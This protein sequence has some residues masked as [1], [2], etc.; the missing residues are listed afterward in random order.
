MG[1]WERAGG[2]PCGSEAARTRCSFPLSRP[3]A[4]A[5]T[6]QSKVEAGRLSDVHRE[7]AT[8]S[9]HVGQSPHRSRPAASGVPA[10]SVSRPACRALDIQGDPSR[11]RERSEAPG[12][13]RGSALFERIRAAN[14][15]PRGCRSGCASCRPLRVGGRRR[16]ARASRSGCRRAA[17]L[18]AASGSGRARHRRRSRPW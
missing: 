4:A 13:A 16:C 3:L 8:G 6:C 17:C 7:P 2:V 11:L 5:S 9:G 10:E 14:P 1:R 18:R 12:P 15:R